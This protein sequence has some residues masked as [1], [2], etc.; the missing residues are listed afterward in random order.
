MTDE[1]RRLTARSSSSWPR[2]QAKEA[3]VCCVGR[4]DTQVVT[5]RGTI[6]GGARDLRPAAR[7]GRHSRLPA[8]PHRQPWKRGNPQHVRHCGPRRTM[9]VSGPWGFSRPS[10]SLNRLHLRL[11]PAPRPR[12][13]AARHTPLFHRA[14][15]HRSSHPEFSFEKIA[16]PQSCFS[17]LDSRHG[18]DP[19]C[20][21]ALV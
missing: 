17:D 4:F 15:A 19:V 7:G 13:M 5:P 14:T 16:S 8:F 18:S 1:G 21:Q 12:H 2:A 20:R 3:H 10:E 9:D 6:A 11:P